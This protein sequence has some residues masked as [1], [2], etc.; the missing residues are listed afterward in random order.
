MKKVLVLGGKPIG[1]VELVNR[2][3]ELGHY[4]IVTD[5]LPVGESP[6][7]AIADECWDVSTADIDELHQRIKNSHIDAVM[8]GVHEFNISRML[9]LCELAKLPCYCTIDRWKDCNNKGRFK[10]LCRSNNIPTA[11]VYSL[12][13]VANNVCSGDF[14]L[15][16]K[17][18][19]GS[20]SRGFHIC[21]DASELEEYYEK[22][23][24][25]SASR[26]VLIEQFIPYDAVIIH[27]TMVNGK[28][29]YSGMSDKI[30]VRFKSTGASVM[31]IQTFPSKGET[32]YL[33]NLN[34]RVERMFENA[35][36]TDGPIW[37]EAFY[38]GD[39][40]F[41]FNEMGYRFGGSLTYYPVRYFYGLDQLDLMIQCALGDK[42]DT[43]ITPSIPTVKKHYCI[44][45]I[46]IKP[47]VIS[48]VSVDS[49]ISNSDD[50]V[51]LVPVHFIGDRIQ[52][53]GSAQQVYA[54]AHFVYTD[55]ADLISKS[56]NL[57]NGIN[58]A[59]EKGDQMIHTLFDVNTIDV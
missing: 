38:D 55:K 27:Y 12:K 15:I 5:Y 33:S 4:V 6:A 40:S 47:G 24:A 16:V 18:I 7:K 57:L 34:E 46:H 37:I 21:N 58:V 56:N 2:L 51:A 45:P 52:D 29:I 10:E 43:V 1:S 8:T 35:G 14:P 13:E 11:K 23:K 49:S 26:N 41:I 28:C 59:D 25:F 50:Y 19:D 48:S 32:A 44:L 53:W 22:A 31:G 39:S 30:S 36:F 17:P 9:E 54:Y 42:R 20:G 3:H